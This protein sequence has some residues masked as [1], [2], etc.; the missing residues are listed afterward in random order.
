MKKI[1]IITFIILVLSLLGCFAAIMMLK[2]ESIQ[3]KSAVSQL[4]KELS[5]KEGAITSLKKN[6]PEFL[7]IN[8][9]EYDVAKR[10]VE[11]KAFILGLP[12]SDS[13][14]LN[15]IDAGTVISVIDA[16]TMEDGNWLYVEIPVYDAPCN[17]KGWRKESDTVPYTKDRI[18]DVLG[19]VT[20]KDGNRLMRGRIMDQKNGMVELMCPGGENILVKE[21]SLIFPEVN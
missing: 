4:T 14:K 9:F 8:Y 6:A 2:T 7:S 12:Y 13:I 15:T 21:S 19:E 11:K 20:F 1:S 18:K 17:M 16:A 5:L 3:L 10:F